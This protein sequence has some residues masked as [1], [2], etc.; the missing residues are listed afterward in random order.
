MMRVKE[1]IF[2]T[3]ILLSILMAPSWCQFPSLTDYPIK[4][5]P[6]DSIVPNIN[7][8]VTFV[9]NKPNQINPEVTDRFSVF[10][11]HSPFRIHRIYFPADGSPSTHEYTDPFIAELG[12]IQGGEVN[13]YYFE[14]ETNYLYT[15]T[16][17]GVFLRFRL[18]FDINSTITMLSY[19]YMYPTVTAH[20]SKCFDMIRLKTGIFAVRMNGNNISIWNFG[21]FV[22]GFIYPYA[23][24]VFA[25]V[26]N[27]P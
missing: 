10:M 8:K 17:F 6:T 5:M 9:V 14:E 21:G 27:P 3:S 20:R 18:N 11:S 25:A 2:L 22:S 26:A 4:M 1:R 13:C 12:G 24:N 19:D 15:G 16:I 23:V 7:T